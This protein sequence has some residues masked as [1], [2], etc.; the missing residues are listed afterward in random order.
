MLQ[1]DPAASLS[2]ITEPEH[3]HIRKHYSEAI[4][5]LVRHFEGI[6]LIY[7]TYSAGLGDD[8]IYHKTVSDAPATITTIDVRT[9]TGTHPYVKLNAHNL[10]W[11][12]AGRYAVELQSW[13][14]AAGDPQHAAFGRITFAPNGSAGFDRVVAAMQIVRD[15]LSAEHLQ[16][17]ALLDGFR[18]TAVWIPFADK[19]SYDRL[20]PW[21]HAFAASLAGSHPDLL[22][23]AAR[24]V[25]RTDRVS[26]GT[27]TNYPGMGTL[28]PYALLGTPGL[29]V[30]TPIRWEQLSSS[31]NGSV[32]AA[33]FV[34]YQRQNGDV[35][36][37]LLEEIGA[38]QFGTREQQR[39][40][41]SRVAIALSAPEPSPKGFIIEAA[42]QILSDGNARDA[43]DILAAALSRDL[44]P[45]STTRKYVY[46]ALHEYVER[47]LGAG[48]IP[49]LIQL[50]GTSSFR[51]NE[52]ADVWPD[53]ALPSLPRWLD[54]VA[55]DLLVQR[56]RDTATALDTASFEVAVCD[57]FSA[58]GFVASHIGGNGAPDGVLAAPLGLAGYRSILECKTAKEGSV[59]A[60][61]RPEEPAKFRDQYDAT[62]A[63]L[64]GPAFGND[65]SLDAELAEHRVAL[66]TVEDLVDCLEA[67]IGPDEIRPLFAP[68]RTE[69]GLRALLWERDHGRRKRVAIIAQLIARQGWSVQ[70]SFARGVPVGQTPILTEE[71]LFVLVDDE[72][73]RLGV[74]SGATID[75]AREAIRQLEASGIV[76]AFDN[77]LIVTQPQAPS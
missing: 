58:L 47:T 18:G 16:S 44:L 65:A 32:T 23:T 63:I 73:I 68:G 49:R 77:G 20:G 12:V 62:L 61:P 55:I 41:L 13:S 69:L 71:T 52:P 35:F 43:A 75:E 51:I 6:P 17:I 57:T 50:T 67:Q 21:L 26:L 1:M 38:Q 36:G 76:R 56:L 42:L 28:L 11:L 14:P 4:P 64:V 39:A 33:N 45:V 59:V 25:D 46:T 15:A 40:P 48:R 60:N 22:T 29:E 2:L 66:W 72:L 19:P 31:V 54:K 27:K 10:T 8:A 24:I 70:Q 7:A 34:E 3:A 9:S 74:T 30:A 53:I 37:A 5:W